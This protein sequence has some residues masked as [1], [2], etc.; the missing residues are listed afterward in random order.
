MNASYL[1]SLTEELLR[2]VGRVG[3]YNNFTLPNGETVQGA[4]ES[5]VISHLTSGRDFIPCRQHRFPG[6]GSG[7]N[8][9]GAVESAG[10]RIVAAR[11]YR[12]QTCRVVTI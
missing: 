8:F 9:S 6:V 7:W 5:E 10:F 1:E 3:P 4:V 11:N 2:V 12:G